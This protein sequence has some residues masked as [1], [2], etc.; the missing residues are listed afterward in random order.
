MQASWWCVLLPSKEWSGGR[1]GGSVSP[2]ALLSGASP[3]DSS[4]TRPVA[5]SIPDDFSYLLH[6]HFGLGIV[7]GKLPLYASIL[8]QPPFRSAGGGHSF[9][10]PLFLRRLGEGYL[11]ELGAG[12]CRSF[13][14]WATVAGYLLMGFANS[15]LIRFRCLIDRLGIVRREHQRAE[16]NLVESLDAENR[17]R[18]MG[19]VEP[20]SAWIRFRGG[21]CRVAGLCF[22]DSASM[23]IA[24]G[25]PS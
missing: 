6:R 2:G 14:S 9:T 4:V 8:V 7:I 25:S 11:I 1:Q 3:V 19:L 16:A 24:R 23:F 15:V 5:D 10:R 13:V 18:A 17:A 12:P 20:A 21:A 22:D